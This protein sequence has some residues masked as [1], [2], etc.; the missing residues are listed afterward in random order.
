MSLHH[1]FQSLKKGIHAS[2]K[3]LM[4]GEHLSTNMDKKYKKKGSYLLR[5][6]YM[7]KIKV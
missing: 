1:G 7:E 3:K 6:S 2:T 5:F 4:T